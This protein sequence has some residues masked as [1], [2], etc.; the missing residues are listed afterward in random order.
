VKG[1][2]RQAKSSFSISTENGRSS[3]RPLLYF[4]LLQHRSIE[5]GTEHKIE[6]CMPDLPLTPTAGIA[7]FT[8]AESLKLVNYAGNS[9]LNMEVFYIT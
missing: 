5:L 4:S 6:I 7:C 1:G 8:V 2:G 3:N 9:W